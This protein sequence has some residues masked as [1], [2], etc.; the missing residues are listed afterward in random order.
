MAWE[1]TP[2]GYLKTKA[3]ITKGGVLQYYGHELGLTD[4]KSNQLVDVVRSIDDL[5]DAETIKS[6]EGLPLTVT[7]P[8][9][10]SVDAKDWKQKT[11]GHIQGV[12]R[13][14]NYIVCDAYIQDADAIELLKNEDIRELSVGYEPADIQKQGDKFYHKNI[15]ANHVAIVAEGRA[16]SDCRLQDNKGKPLMKVKAKRKSL[17]DAIKALL[18]DSS[19]SPEET[20]KKIDELKAE[21]ETVQGKDDEESKTKA[22]ELQKQIDELKAKLA[23]LT[24]ED[25]T[26]EKDSKIAELTAENESLKA[27]VAELEAQVEELK[28]EK[29]KGEAL[30]D[31]RSRFPKV[32]LA[33]AKTAND[34]LIKVLVDHGIYSTDKATKLTDAEIRAAYAGL[35][36]SNAKKTNS[37]VSGLLNDAKGSQAKPASQRLGGK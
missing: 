18:A 16:G 35:V 5:S 11:V 32:N 4:S 8:D 20:N 14:G 31:A 25:S 23:K 13:E 15:R 21:L 27:K 37:M 34:V 36:A 10:K 29:E 1:I 2:Q 28:N 12:K 7:H 33:D 9:K 3:K 22:D 26:D 6:F 17:A 19:L 30:N 24:D